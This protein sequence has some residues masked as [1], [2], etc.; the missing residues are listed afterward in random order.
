[1]KRS[2]VLLLSVVG[3]A[4]FHCGDDGTQTAVLPNYDASAH[5]AYVAPRQE[6]AAVDAG[7]LEAAVDAS[8]DEPVPANLPAA[9]VAKLSLKPYVEDKCVPATYPG[10]PY[11][12]QSCTYYNG[13]QVVVAD[14]P[15]DRVAAWI[16]ESAEYIDTLKSL[17]T[18]DTA[19]YEAALVV[20]AANVMGQSSRIF[21][22]V[23]QIDEGTVYKFKNGV[24][25]TCSTGCFCRINSTSRQMWCAYAAAT[26]GDNEQ[27]CLTRYGTQTFTDAWADKCLENHAAS[28]MKNHNENFRAR[29]FVANKTLATQ[30]PNPA[31]AKG[32]DVVT[33]LKAIFPP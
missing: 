26:Q 7:T 21:P 1:M 8:G 2:F 11:P 13:L 5:D 6:D 24:T 32:S 30:F 19:S 17:K 10:F 14:P 33:A 25:S 23:G 20:I 15:A 4:L 27:A 3:L 22:L 31:T 28:W 12:A 29:A 9:V 16:V 18:R